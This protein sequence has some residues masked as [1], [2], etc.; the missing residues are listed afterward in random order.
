MAP[1]PRQRTTSSRPCRSITRWLPAGELVYSGAH[2]L[3]APLLI[4]AGQATL[5]AQRN[6]ASDQ[7]EEVAVLLEGECLTNATLAW[8]H[9]Q[10]V[11]AVARSPMQLLVLPGAAFAE[12]LQ[13]P[14]LRLLERR[15]SLLGSLPL[16]RRCRCLSSEI[17]S[18]VG[19][20]LNSL[21]TNISC[22]RVCV[23]VCACNNQSRKA[24]ITRDTDRKDIQRVS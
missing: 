6:P 1:Q 21:L 18:P 24:E 10:A 12:R 11:A 9:P 5:L 23:C 8:L 16:L 15:E 19:N 17:T 14:L 2:G 4:L 20:E 3:R 22:V 13:L 7:P